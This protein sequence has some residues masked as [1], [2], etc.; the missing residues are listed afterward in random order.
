MK[1][2]S[3]HE[4]A[5]A[6]IIKTYRTTIRLKHSLR[7]DEEIAKTLPLV[8]KAIDEAL[9]NGEPLELDPASVFTVE[10]P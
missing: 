8:E 5:K 3:M 4:V 2:Y 7:A 9:L 1:P 10:G 6:R